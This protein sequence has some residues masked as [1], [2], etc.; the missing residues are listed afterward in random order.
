M[1]QQTTVCS[2]FSW[3]THSSSCFAQE[4]SDK[5]I[6]I[7]EQDVILSP[8]I[9]Q[10]VSLLPIDKS[11]PTRS[12]FWVPFPLQKPLSRSSRLCQALA[13]AHNAQFQE[14]CRFGLSNFLLQL[15]T[16]SCFRYMLIRCEKT[17]RS[18]QL[19]IYILRQS[20]YVQR[21][22]IL[23]LLPSSNI[24]ILLCSCLADRFEKD[25]DSIGNLPFSSELQ[26]IRTWHRRI[27]CCIFSGTPDL[28]SNSSFKA[29]H[30]CPRLPCCWS[31]E[32]PGACKEV[33]V[34]I[35]TDGWRDGVRG[36]REWKVDA[37]ESLWSR[38]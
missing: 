8:E 2:S 31:I 9:V 16:L 5:L 20:L 18:I 21:C 26:W 3:N 6:V 29:C 35:N 24:T 30:H 17:K 22:H 25:S 12:F 34:L 32:V 19:N 36:S 10:T 15:L 14:F 1:Q 11:L 4:Y 7:T 23:L 13:I 33:T 27:S 38:D 37:A 28:F